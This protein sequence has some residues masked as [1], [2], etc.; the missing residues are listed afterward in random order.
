M[1][2]L[3][4]AVAAT[5]VSCSTSGRKLKIAR[6]FFFTVVVLDAVGGN[7][8]KPPGKAFRILQALEI[9]ISLDENVLT[10]I[11]GIQAGAN[12]EENH[13]VNLLL[14]GVHQLLEGE[15]VL[16]HGRE[17]EGFFFTRTIRV[18]G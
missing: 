2:V 14:I 7:A 11:L 1:S 15:A 8:E 16:F 3:S 13:A 4:P 5:S 12:P 17:D 18:R 9:F 6:T 10:D